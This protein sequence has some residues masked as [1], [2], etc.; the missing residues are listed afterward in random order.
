MDRNQP[1]TFDW[2]VKLLV[3]GDAGVGKTN[4][5]SRFCKDTFSP[6]H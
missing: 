4:I 6:A 3:I 5:L 1:G 2:L